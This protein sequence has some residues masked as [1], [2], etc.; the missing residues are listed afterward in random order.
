MSEPS[1]KKLYEKVKKEIYKKY[2]KH[3]AYRSG[4]LVKEYKELVKRKVIRDYQDGSKKSG[5]LKM[6]KLNI[7][8]K[9]IYLDQLKELVKKPPQL[10]KNYLKVK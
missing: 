6:V 2:P 7:K 10:L 9:M 4:L 8:I 1:D 5:K 3:S